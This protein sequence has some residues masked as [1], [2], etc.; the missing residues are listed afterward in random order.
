MRSSPRS[1][2]LRALSALLGL[3]LMLPAPRVAAQSPGA[4]VSPLQTAFDTVWEHSDLAVHLGESS[5]SW[6]WGPA[7][8][9]SGSET[10]A[11]SA[12]GLRLVQYYDKG[13]LEINDA[14]NPD[15]V[16][17]GL[18]VREMVTGSIALGD[19]AGQLE[20]RAPARIAVAGDP[21]TVNPDAPTYAS[22]GA[23][24]A[25]AADQP[26]APAI[27]A[28]VT[29]TIDQ[30]GAIGE[31]PPDVAWLGDTVRIAAFESTLRHNV[32]DV[33]WRFLTQRGVVYQDGQRINDQPL[34]NWPVITGWPISEPYW[35]VT[36]VGGQ[37]AWVL[38]QLYE[39][40][41]LTYTPANPESLRVEMGNVGQHYFAWRYGRL[42]PPDR[43]LIGEPAANEL[44]PRSAV[45]TWLSDTLLQPEIHFGTRTTALDGRAVAPAPGMGGTVRLDGLQPATRYFWRAVGVRAGGETARSALYSFTTPPDPAAPPA[46]PPGA[47]IVCLTFDDGPMPGSSNVLDVLGGRVPAMFFLTGANLAGNPQAQAALVSRILGEGHQIG[48]H[49]F[50]HYPMTQSGYRHTYGDLRSPAAYAQFREN[51]ERNERHFQAILGVHQRLFTLARL[52]GD[53]RIFPAYV[54]ATRELGMAHV[55]WSFELAPNGIY[56]H[57]PAWNWQGVGGIAASSPGLPQPGAIILLHDHHFGGRG[58]LLAGVIQT[59]AGNGYGFGRIAADGSCAP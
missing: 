22:F 17:A 50:T 21:L 54:N 24:V 47:Q 29:H 59:L 33:F 41:A 9:W 14:S 55:D 11:Q 32:P 31:L 5:R 38:V 12:D 40:R 34:W 3:S 15:A 36:R 37:P 16:T 51:Y 4:A 30:A 39:R 52:P 45:V 25:L 1:H 53:G 46:A 19:A 27:G 13:R 58:G 28:R 35:L 43:S 26:A 10:Y 48:N 49:T 23:V 42:P 6:T 44:T 18:L 20:S 7:I 2:A 8:L 56:S 57:L